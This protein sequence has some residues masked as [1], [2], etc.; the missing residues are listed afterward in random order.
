MLKTEKNKNDNLVIEKI[1]NTLIKASSSFRPDKIKLLKDRVKEE[2]NGL[3]K[4][5]L[6]SIIE[7]EKIAKKNKTPLC[8]DTGIPHI[9]LEVGP[10]SKFDYRLLE[11]IEKGISKGL[12]ELP[13]RP[14]AV[15]GND[16]Q[17]IEQSQGLYHKSS[18]LK[19][20]PIGIKKMKKDGLKINI[21]M[22]GGGPE[23]RATT[24]RVFHQRKI[25][26][27]IDEIITLSKDEIKRLGCTPCTLAIGIGRTHYEANS[28]ML[29][30][31]IRGRF[32]KQ[33]KIEKEITKRL[34]ESN[35]GPLGLSGGNTVLATFLCVGPQRASGVRIVSLRP[36]CIIEPRV[37]SCFL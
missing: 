35:I 9:L 33:N 14:M 2:K 13:G 30:A 29:E 19:L 6:E 11:N 34:N 23:I 5:V 15:R 12:E 26:I 18:D 28:L 37:A 36:C 22:Q 24:K 7:N 20:A 3:L 8:D 10:N 32:N 21:L 16:I 25:S 31:M 27:I 17:R 4:W 1:K